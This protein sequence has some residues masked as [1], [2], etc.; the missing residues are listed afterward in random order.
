[1]AGIIVTC[2]LVW[3]MS[4][5]TDEDAVAFYTT[6][7]GHDEVACASQLLVLWL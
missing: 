4:L 3:S 2:D 7:V 5:L 1:M 6:A